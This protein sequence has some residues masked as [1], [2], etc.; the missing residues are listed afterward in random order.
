[1]ATTTERDGDTSPPPHH[2][3]AA[4]PT[5][6]GVLGGL[7]NPIRR[8]IERTWTRRGDADAAAEAEEA[9]Q[10]LRGGGSEFEASTAML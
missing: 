4:L 9:R 8:A 3:S 7:S 10:A 6:A 5:A 1:M 2:W